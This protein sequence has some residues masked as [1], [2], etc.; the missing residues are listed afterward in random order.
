MRR[1]M[2]FIYGT[3]C[4]VMFLGTFGYAIGFLV[5]FAV[6]RSIDKGPAT[7]PSTAIVVNIL[8]LGLFG[9]QHSVMARPTFKKW[10]TRYVPEPIERSTY[11]LFT[12]IVLIL[13]FWQW[14]PINGIVWDVQGELAR[15][16]IYALFGLGWLVVFVSTVMLNHLD[17]FGMRQVWLHLLGRQYTRLPFKVPVFYRYARHPLYVGWLMTFW[18]TPT[19]TAGHLLFAAVNTAYILI[20][21]RLEERNLI[22]A[23][24]DNYAEYRRMVPMLIPKPGRSYNTSADAMTMASPGGSM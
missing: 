8:L 7:A 3:I 17:L 6:P 15:T 13:L 24:G 20:A 14:R 18:I 1:V 23:H 19:M 10:W 11:V 12:N 22:E 2:Y 16:S 4:Y 21:I 9:L 5:N